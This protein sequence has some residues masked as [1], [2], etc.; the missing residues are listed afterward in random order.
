MTWKPIG[1]QVLVKRQDKQETTKN[2]II[3]MRG[4][5]EYVTCEVIAVGNG[6]IVNGEV[7]PLTVTSGQQVKIYSGN[8]SDHKKVTIDDVEYILLHESE[9]GLVNQQ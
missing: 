8:L 6:S 2:G 5:D 1:T 4:L 7:I 3:M 9:I